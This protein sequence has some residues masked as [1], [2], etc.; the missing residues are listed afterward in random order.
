M[1]EAAP[2]PYLTRRPDLFPTAHRFGVVTGV[3]AGQVKL[4]VRSAGKQEG[5]SMR[6]AS[7]AAVSLA[8]LP[9]WPKRCRRP[10][11]EARN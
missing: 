10:Q 2:A 3:A 8:V 7:I 4:F 6:V 9:F 11:E 1:Q 5:V